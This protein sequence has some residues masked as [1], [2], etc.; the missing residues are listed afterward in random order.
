VKLRLI[1]NIRVGLAGFGKTGKEV[2]RAIENDPDA[3]LAWILVKEKR[4]PEQ[5]NHELSS[6]GI[7]R[8]NR[9]VFISETTMLEQKLRLGTIDALIDFSHEENLERLLKLAVTY[10]TPFV[11]AVSHYS[12]EA[13]NK[14]HYASKK[15][16]VIWAPN[17]TVG[18]NFLFLAAKAFR[19]ANPAVDIQISEEHFREKKGVSGTALRLADMLGE[20]EEDI[21]SVRAGGIVGIH[22]VLFGSQNETIRLR[23]ESISRQAFGNGALFAARHLTKKRPGFYSMEDFILPYFTMPLSE[24]GHIPKQSVRTQRSW[25]DKFTRLLG[26]TKK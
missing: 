12:P 5:A 1:V 17:I 22:E 11:S 25:V 15:I 16:P 21:N 9:P 23:H 2:A 7:S 10:Q 13:K 14:L 3:D 26:K 20:P 24:T 4:N 18:I 8:V 6:A 19:M